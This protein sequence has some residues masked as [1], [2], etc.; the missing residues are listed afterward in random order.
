[1]KSVTYFRYASMPYGFRDETD[2]G[3]SPVG[4]LVRPSGTA[5]TK[6]QGAFT[7][8]DI[9]TLAR[10]SPHVQEISWDFLDEVSGGKPKVTTTGTVTIKDGTITIK[11][12]QTTVEL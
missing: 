11:G 1:V 10:L 4:D 5:G 9:S 7:M 12:G 8:N 3:W 6:K 2:A